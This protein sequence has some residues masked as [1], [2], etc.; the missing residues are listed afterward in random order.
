MVDLL[1]IVV[2]SIPL[3]FHRG[4]LFLIQRALHKSSLSLMNRHALTMQETN[5][6]RSTEHVNIH[7]ASYFGCYFPVTFRVHG[8]S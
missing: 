5:N 1:S 6:G 7:I 3:S 8:M 2:H 4:F